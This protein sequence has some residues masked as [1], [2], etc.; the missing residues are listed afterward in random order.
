MSSKAT[1]WK[2]GRPIEHGVE[3][4]GYDCSG[5]SELFGMPPD[6]AMFQ[7]PVIQV[8]VAQV[9]WNKVT[10]IDEM[11]ALLSEIGVLVVVGSNMH[12]RLK[13]WLKDS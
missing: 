4:A 13:R 6:Q 3:C 11:K 2:C 7:L 5:A 8:P 1:C 10:S 12:A 9:D